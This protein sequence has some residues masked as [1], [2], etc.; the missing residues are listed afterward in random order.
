MTQWR[1]RNL[2]DYYLVCHGNYH[3]ESFFRQDGGIYGRFNGVAIFAYVFGIVV[4]LPFV[5]TD[6]YTGPVARRLDG[7]DISW[8][9][10]LVLTSLV[11]YVGCKRFA[12]A[13]ALRVASGD[14]DLA[15]GI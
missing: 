1:A 7:A 13:G 4:Q 11:Y 14:A 12:R 2:I 9:V 10:G 8:I 6:L 15:A 3:I 5:A